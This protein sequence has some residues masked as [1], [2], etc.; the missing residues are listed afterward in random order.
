MKFSLGGMKRRVRLGNL[1]GVVSGK[2]CVK[3][4]C[5]P[6]VINANRYLK[7]YFAEDSNGIKHLE[8]LVRLTCCNFIEMCI[9]PSVTAWVKIGQNQSKC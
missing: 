2:P 9:N 3:G 8:K 6:V 4:R 1:V 7:A 5:K